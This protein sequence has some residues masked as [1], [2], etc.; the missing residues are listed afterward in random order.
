[1][2][3][4]DLEAYLT[5]KGAQVKRSG[6]QIHT[7]CMFCHEDSSGRGRLY[8]DD[9]SDETRGLY[10][11]KLCDERGNIHT[12]RKHFGDPPLDDGRSQR[13][14]VSRK[15]LN[16]ANQ[17][18]H[19]Q[20]MPE[21]RSWLKTNRGLTDEIIDRFKFGSAKADGLGAHL[22]ALGYSL[23]DMTATG[24]VRADKKDFLTNCVT[25][26]YMVAGSTVQIRGKQVGAKYLTPPGQP[27]RMFNTDAVWG[28]AEVVITEGE[29]DAIT[30]TQLGF[31][32]VAVPG[33][34][35]WQ[36]AWTAYFEDAT[37]VFIMYD[38]DEHGQKGRLKVEEALGGRA[39]NVV[40]PVPDGEA[41]KNVDANW[42]VAALHWGTQDFK[43]ILEDSIWAN[44]LLLS[45]RD[46]FA[47][48][49]SVQGQ[50]GFK[51]GFEILD[52][53]LKPG[54]M[55]GQVMVPLAKTNSGKSIILLNFAQ[56]ATMIQPDAKILLISLEQTR[57]DWFER[58]R[59][60]WNFYNLECDPADV[61][62]KSLEYW[63]DRIRLVDKNRVT[64]E[65]MATILVEYEE[66]M[67]QKPDL[68]MVDYLGY[69]ARS[70]K[71]RDRYEQV[72]DAIME[73]K[74]IAKDF[75]IPIIAPHQVNRSAEFGEEFS[76]DQARDSGV[77]EETADF[78]LSL[79]NADSLK[80]REDEN[81]T[82]TLN[83]GIGKS[84]H[85]GKGQKVKL[86][87]GYMTLTIMEHQDKLAQM[88]RREVDWVL[89]SRLDWRDAIAA[90]RTGST[91]K[92]VTSRGLR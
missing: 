39:K 32:A 67:G 82:G 22:H 46:A 58:V 36:D 25:I 59:R 61:N 43:N 73:L 29:F 10:H 48:W 70:F 65:E 33:A 12:L 41:A 85:G 75:R 15:I 86:Q 1:M 4:I 89:D 71:A 84:R 38:P 17:F 7:H 26:P 72:A 18:Y 76:I 44:S 66:Q 91:P 20:L 69:W 35:S 37:R 3:T 6:S 51:L 23:E 60:I 68:V 78:A 87:F 40:L 90:H 16:A 42:L 57:G 88:A 83:L 49:E 11:C 5:E 74:A 53:L 27:A 92:V 79:W 50:D 31:N 55:P 13:V 28:A 21:H 30:L 52:N 63:D 77:I 47:E 81:R 54:L 62:R 56:R 45:P 80:G 9:S 8:F 64:P 14:D 2:S 24:L 34:S 19:Q